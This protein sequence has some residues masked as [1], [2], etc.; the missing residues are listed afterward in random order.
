MLIQR[1][2]REIIGLVIAGFDI[3]NTS[4]GLSRDR[5]PAADRRKFRIV[6]LENPAARQ[7]VACRFQLIGRSRAI[8]LRDNE[9]GLEGIDRGPQRLQHIGL[10]HKRVHGTGQ[11]RRGRAVSRSVSR[12]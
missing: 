11:M 1:T 6:G 9:I 8:Q 10:D 4:I 5:V 7:F 2:T 12:S 3:I